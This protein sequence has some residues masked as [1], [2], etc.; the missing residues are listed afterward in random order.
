MY[1]K[2]KIFEPSEKVVS[3]FKSKHSDDLTVFFNV[4]EIFKYLS[5]SKMML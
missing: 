4:I 1:V 3:S 2:S 5:N